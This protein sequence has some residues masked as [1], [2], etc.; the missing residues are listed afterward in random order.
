[1]QPVFLCFVLGLRSKAAYAWG[2]VN[3]ELGGGVVVVGGGGLVVW[4]HC[5]PLLNALQTPL[6]LP[7]I[8]SLLGV[9]LEMEYALNTS[10]CT[11]SKICVS[12]G[13]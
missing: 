7:L 11:L 9:A 12:A 4:H 2:D 8:F 6:S 5:A 1:M 13:H 10:Y 3:R